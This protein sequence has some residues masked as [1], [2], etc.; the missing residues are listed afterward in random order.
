MTFGEYILVSLF[1]LLYCLVHPRDKRNGYLG[2]VHMKGVSARESTFIVQKGIFSLPYWLSY[3]GL[4]CPRLHWPLE[5][6]VITVIPYP[7]ELNTIQI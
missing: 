4:N 3:I 2:H 5:E 1:M 6:S 7:E